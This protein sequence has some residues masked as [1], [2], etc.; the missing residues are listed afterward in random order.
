MSIIIQGAA[1]RRHGGGGFTLL[2]WLF[3]NLV[4]A[5]KDGDVCVPLAKRIFL[6][7]GGDEKGGVAKIGRMIF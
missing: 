2:E 4:V 7:G 1:E 5:R 6:L 3:S